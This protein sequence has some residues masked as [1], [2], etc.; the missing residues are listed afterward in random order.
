M[1][2]KTNY[3]QIILKN[4]C[5][6]FTPILIAILL[7]SVALEI[8]ANNNSEIT[9]VDNYYES[10]LFSKRYFER[11]KTKIGDIERAQNSVFYSKNNNLNK[12]I[13][14]YDKYNDCENFQYLIIDKTRDIVITNVETYY[15][16][17]N[18]ELIKKEIKKSNMY[19]TLENGVIDTSIE[20]L[21]E[22]D[23]KEEDL[24][25]DKNDVCVYTSINEKLPYMDNI[26][27]DFIAYTAYSKIGKYNQITIPLISI[28]LI[29]IFIIVVKSIGKNKDSSEDEIKLNIIDKI[30]LEIITLL[31]LGLILTGFFVCCLI[32]SI[33]RVSTINIIFIIGISIMYIS[34]IIIF[35]TIIKR[36]KA[37]KL[38]TT[39][40]IYK[41][42]NLIKGF[43]ENRKY[44]TRLVI[45][46]LGFCILG[47]LLTILL[48]MSYKTS[49]KIFCIL[50]LMLLFIFTFRYLYKKT[51]QYKKV[52]ETL[53]NIYEG[54][55]NIK[56]VDKELTGTL[57]NMAMYI[58]D[59][60]SGFSNA[61]DE[62]LKS[63]RLKT[64]LITNVSHDIKT[65]LTSI[66]NYVDLLK[67]E[68]MPNEKSKEYLKILENKSYRLKRLIEDLVEASKASSG[69]IKLNIE[70]INIKELINQVSGEFEEKFNKKNL[71]EV[72]TTQEED[73]IINADSRYMYRIFENIYSN[74]SKYA[75][76]NTRV[77][78]DVKTSKDKVNIQIKN[79]SKEKLNITKE[80]LMQ[81]FVRGDSSR[82]TEGSGLG[83]SIAS[84]LTK[85]QKGE[86]NIYLDGDLFKIILEFKKV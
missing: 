58:N 29:G 37:G 63:E 38:W 61:V 86:F 49:I 7:G 24:M 13:Y 8:M 48:F 67:N 82:N 3:I 21:N 47:Y 18:L 71:I 32:S 53:K 78:V 30:P 35:E 62:K 20:K 44:L 79:V 6:I 64:E 75:L 76:E 50:I 22:K 85:L 84:S 51:M 25:F 14:Y 28:I 27:R 57:K 74:I 19:W 41:I 59:I 65:P 81:R 43:I 45:C 9:V 83:L 23:I 70:K 80:E 42:V 60:A 56:L 10:N 12:N 68:K 39:T 1:E 40:L 16:D 5:Y 54:N 73:I 36:I 31:W 55:I 33:K 66:I 46:Y 17:D 2:N 15:N 34:S 26:Y 4:L 69:N 72:I 11:L 77:Y 52:E